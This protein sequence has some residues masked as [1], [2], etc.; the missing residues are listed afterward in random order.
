MTSPTHLVGQRALHRE[1]LVQEALVELLFWLMHHDDSVAMTV[2]LRPPCTPHHLQSSV[3][4]CVCVCECVEGEPE[5]LVEML[6]LGSCTM[7]TA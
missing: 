6:F 2:V 1:G 3:F 5:A 4:G 7:M